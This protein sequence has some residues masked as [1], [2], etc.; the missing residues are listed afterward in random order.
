MNN[1][2]DPFGRIHDKPEPKYSNNGWLYTAVAIRSRYIMDE[3]FDAVRDCIRNLERHPYAT[4]SLPP[5]SR[6]E[7][8]GLSYLAPLTLLNRLDGWSFCPYQK[9]KFNLIKFLKEAWECFG[10]HRNYFWVNGKTHIY[11]VAFLVP[12][13]DRYFLLK[14]AERYH[15]VCHFMYHL[16]HLIDQLIPAKNRSERLIKYLKGKNDIDAV[17]NYFGN[18]HPLTQFIENKK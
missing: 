15:F 8:L 17:S 1:Y 16:I 2:I 18:E 9:P 6:D 7:I 11:H 4:G 10:Q 3:S 13:Q 12:L 5:I 14:N